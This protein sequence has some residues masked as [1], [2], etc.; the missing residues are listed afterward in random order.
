MEI[1]NVLLSLGLEVVDLDS[2]S[3]E[4]IEKKITEEIEY[5]EQ[6][7]SQL[8]SEKESLSKSNE[9]LTASVEGYKASEEKLNKDLSE[10]REKLILTEGKL[11]QITELYKENFT[12]D[13]NMQE[14]P[15]KEDKDLHNDVLQQ[16][17]D[18]K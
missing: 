17:L 14:Q 5:K 11:Y 2:M 9:E 13:P 12:K 4:E 10:T 3:D 6:R 16:I 1:K 7:I 15:V 8:E 18:T